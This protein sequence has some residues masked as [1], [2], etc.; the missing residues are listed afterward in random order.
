M[1]KRKQKAPKWTANYFDTRELYENWSKSLSQK[2]LIRFYG[3]KASVCPQNATLYSWW[4][5]HKSDSIIR[6]STQI[7]MIAVIILSH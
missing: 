6:S 2:D 5:K 7:N 3:D 1:S 4:H